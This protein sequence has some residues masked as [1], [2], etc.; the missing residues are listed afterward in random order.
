MK[1]ES[2]N[3]PSFHL[4]SVL[5]SNDVTDSPLEVGL[6]VSLDEGV[7]GSDAAFGSPFAVR[8]RG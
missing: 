8:G 7:D 2:V 4:S 5:R 3:F 1:S 6:G